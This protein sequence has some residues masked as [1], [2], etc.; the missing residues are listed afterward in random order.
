MAER[1]RNMRERLILAGIAE[2]NEHGAS[3]FSIRRVATACN[4]SC[5]APYKHF[6]DK[7]DFVLAIIEHVNGQWHERQQ[8]VLAACADEP[9]AKIVE[10]CVQYVRFLMEKPHFRSVLM[11]KD[12]QFDNLYHRAR[13]QI[14]STMQQLQA[15]FFAQSGY[16]KATILR[17][18]LL[19]R[20]MIF[21]SVFLFDAG[22]V[23]YNEEALESIRY[24]IDREFDLV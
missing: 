12:K 20:S 1:S 22:E 17:K 4:V 24:N 10:V 6:K 13:G 3:D 21:G 23:E 15:D 7:R 11:L 16:D 8:Q 14:S 2:I 19:V 5:A 9:R 18:L